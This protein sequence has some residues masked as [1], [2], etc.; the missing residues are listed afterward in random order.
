MP[1]ITTSTTAIMTY[2]RGCGC[3]CSCATTS[4]C[5]TPT[6]SPPLPESS[7]PVVMVGASLVRNQVHD[8]EDHDPH[9]VDE[10]PVQTGDLDGLGLLGGQLALQRPLV[11][12]QEP[13]D[14]DRDVRAV[15]AGHHE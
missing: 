13:E 6:S 4:P 5:S 14:A 7:S 8:R 15:E 10:V 3:R 11:D 1:V 2:W 12:R 9:D